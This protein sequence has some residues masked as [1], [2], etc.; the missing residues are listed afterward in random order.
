VDEEVDHVCDVAYTGCPDTVVLNS[1]LQ[2]S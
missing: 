2:R 1:H